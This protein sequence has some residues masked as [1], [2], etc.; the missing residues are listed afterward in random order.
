MDI[1]FG[2]FSATD[3]LASCLLMTL[4]KAGLTT[5]ARDI[6]IVSRFCLS[7]GHSRQAPARL[8]GK[9]VIFL[10]QF[11]LLKDILFLTFIQNE[12]RDIVFKI[13]LQLLINSQLQ[14]LYPESCS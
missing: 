3:K 12:A 6:Q 10:K 4:S 14:L 8:V 9:Q 1:R 11:Q 13:L 2:H 7:I 5:G